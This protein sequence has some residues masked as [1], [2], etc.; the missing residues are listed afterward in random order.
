MDEFE[1]ELREAFERIP[2]PP[3]L[4]R[5]LIAE[6]TRRRGRKILRFPMHWQRLAASVALAAALTGGA[7]WGGLKWQEREERRKGE[8]ARDQ[9]LIALRLTGRALDHMNRQLAEHDSQEQKEEHR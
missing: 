1:Q 5:N 2:A 3:S 4:K 9:V 8:A 7:T 6:R